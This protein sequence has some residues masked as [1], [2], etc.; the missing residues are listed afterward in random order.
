MVSTVDY[1]RNQ[2]GKE[3]ADKPAPGEVQALASAKAGLYGD[4]FGTGTG[5]P[6]SIPG[7]SPSSGC[8]P[9][10]PTGTPPSDGSLGQTSSSSGF[11]PGGGSLAG[12]NPAT[13]NLALKSAPAGC[14]PRVSPNGGVASRGLKGSAHPDGL[15]LDTYLVCGG[16]VKYGGS[17]EMNQYITNLAGNG[18]R[19]L[20]YYNAGFVHADLKGQV[21][22]RWGPNQDYV[23][24]LAAGRDPGAAPANAAQ[25]AGGSGGGDPCAGGGGGSGC[26]PISSTAPQIAAGLSQNL[27][28]DVPSLV[29]NL[30]SVLTSG[31]PLGAAM[32]AVTGA[33]QNMLGLG[34]A[35]PL[36]PAALADPTSAITQAV[37]NQVSSMGASIIPSI[38][39]NIPP[40]LATAS[41]MAQGFVTDKIT[42]TA[43]QVFGKNSP[44]QLEKFISIFNAALAAQGFANSLQFTINSTLNNVFGRAG[45]IFQNDAINNWANLPGVSNADNPWI[46]LD[47]PDIGEVK[48]A[49]DSTIAPNQFIGDPETVLDHVVNRRS[50]NAFS[51]IFYDWDAYV[52]RG[53]GT[54]TN[55]VTELG[56][57]FIALGRMA[58]LN[59]MLRIGTPGQ[60]AQ[61]IIVYGAGISCGLLQYMKQNELTITDLSDPI[62]DNDIATFL[63]SVVDP[64]AIDAVMQA[65]EIDPTLNPQS[66]GDLLDPQWILPRSYDYNYFINLNDIAVFLSMLF[67]NSRGQMTTISQLGQLLVSFEIPFDTSQI[68]G[69]PATYDY[70][71]I[72]DLADQYAPVGLFTSDGSLSV[73][74]FIGTAAGYIHAVTIPRIAE[75]QAEL[76]DTT[77]YFDDYVSLVDLLTDTLDGVYTVINIPPTPNTVQPPTT[78]GYSFGT[79]S[80]MDAAVTAIVSAI[81][82]ELA[83]AKTAIDTSNNLTV[84]QLMRELDS[85]HYESSL[86]LARE[87][88]LRKEYG[89]KLG[90]TKKTDQFIGDGSVTVLPLSVDIDASEDIDVYISGV[91]QAP[92]SYTVNATAN[93]ITLPT[94]PAFGTKVAVVYRTDAFDGRANKLQV[95]EFASNLENLA[96]ETGNGR[97]ADFIRKVVTDDK[98]GQRIASALMLARNKDRARAAGINSSNFET[99]DGVGPTYTSYTEWTGIWADTVE[100]ASQLYLEINQDLNDY[101]EYMLNKYAENADAMK[102]DVELLMLNTVRQLVF[103]KDNSIIA[104]D[105]LTLIYNDNTVDSLAAIDRTDLSLSFTEDDLPEDGIVLGPANEI[106]SQFMRQEGLDN[107]VYNIDL[108]T[109]TRSYLSAINVDLA[110]AVALIQRIMMATLARHLGITEQRAK[111]IFGLQS[112]SKNLLQN[113]ANGY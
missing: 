5:A 100:R 90:P 84:I 10:T 43:N 14:Q 54:L 45:F 40:E 69:D 6:G 34:G 29:Q 18:A 12:V 44:P 31:N 83:Q 108:S 50:I 87:H 51:S 24:N 58:D 70:R 49:I 9:G 71:Q 4:R 85:L 109:A 37:A 2:A 20:S 11:A 30:G 86:Q 39:G 13:Q 38:A 22:R 25:A 48:S 103:I 73:A 60:I 91:W 56:Y 27:G 75:I 8:A 33:A 7:G 21:P 89:F 53:F 81:E 1:S 35:I 32:S 88:K 16:Q 110:F 111:E 95:W 101:T 57:D 99:N 23:N 105:I 97:G 47:G 36:S 72:S 93:T 42:T 59:D 62:Y 46:K 106:I 68:G 55:N 64:D 63:K 102:S 77:T 26:Q 104:S 67:V 17:P 96:K 112:L 41:G 61:Q 78:A 52:T 3:A 19:G 82:T 79:Y 107:T 98:Y 76:Y 65:L 66:L 94:A 74:D 28:M 15:A 113:I 92:T 80:T